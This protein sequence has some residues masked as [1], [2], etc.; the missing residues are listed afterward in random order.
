MSRCNTRQQN[1]IRDRLTCDRNPKAIHSVAQVLFW[2]ISVVAF[3]MPLGPQH[4]NHCKPTING[5]IF[6]F[7]ECQT[8]A[9]RSLAPMSHYAT[10]QAVVRCGTVCVPMSS[11]NHQSWQGE[12]TNNPDVKKPSAAPAWPWFQESKKGKTGP[13]LCGGSIFWSYLTMNGKK[14]FTRTKVLSRPL[15]E[16]KAMCVYILYICLF[17]CGATWWFRGLRGGS[18]LLAVLNPKSFR[19]YECDPRS[20]TQ[21]ETFCGRS[22]WGKGVSWKILEKPRGK[23]FVLACIEMGSVKNMRLCVLKIELQKKTPS[24]RPCVLEASD[25][26]R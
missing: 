12:R 2:L 14:Y 4:A 18:S 19:G 10:G 6:S 5:S 25:S 9:G 1:A 11:E 17:L 26:L 16:N 15:F 24:T 8:G 13:L 23:T 20:A 7:A 3:D 22:P 21:V